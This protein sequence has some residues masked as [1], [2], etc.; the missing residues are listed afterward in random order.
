[1]G[2]ADAQVAG[3]LFVVEDTILRSDIERIAASQLSL[4][5]HELEKQLNR[6][7]FADLLAYL[8]SQ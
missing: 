5:P 3:L 1:M 8:K 4:M 6:Q 2:R 7:D